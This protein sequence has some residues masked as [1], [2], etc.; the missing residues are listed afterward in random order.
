M[1]RIGS[2]VIAGVGGHADFA[3]AGA[4]S[5]RGASIIALP[6]HRGGQS[7]LVERLASA[8]STS[9]SDVDVVITEHGMVDLRG[10]DDRERADALRSL[11]GW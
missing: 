1:E 11:W 7:T 5:V 6:S 3:M 4:R 10:L 8:T 2:D 9:R